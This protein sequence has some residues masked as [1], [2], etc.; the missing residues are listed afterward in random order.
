MEFAPVRPQTFLA[1]SITAHCN[2]RH[3]PKNG[4]LA[5]LAYLDERTFPSLPRE[6]NPGKSKI[7]WTFEKAESADF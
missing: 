2:P 1:K 5:S 3:I 7:P 4:I 6:P